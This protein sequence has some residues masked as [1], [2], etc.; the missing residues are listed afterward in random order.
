M[1]NWRETGPNT[2]KNSIKPLIDSSHRILTITV[3]N[4]CKPRQ[5]PWTSAPERQVKLSCEITMALESMLSISCI[6]LESKLLGPKVCRL[7]YTLLEPGEPR[8]NRRNHVVFREIERTTPCE[9]VFD[10]LPVEPPINPHTLQVPRPRFKLAVFDMDS[11]LVDQE[12]IDELARSIGLT[13]AV[14]A[15]TARAMN[16]EIDFEE[17]LKE[18]VALLKG[19]RAD[20]WDALQTN[21][22]ITI[23]KGAIELI[24]RLR[25]MGVITAVVSGGFLPMAD[26]LKMQLGLNYASANH[27]LTSPPS[28]EYP[29]E[30][31]NGLLDPEKQIV[32]AQQKEQLLRCLARAHGIG[33]EQTLAVGDGSN[34]LLMMG[35][36]A[37]GV[38]WKA[39]ASVQ[40]KAPARLNGD[41]L[42]ELLYLFG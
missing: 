1:V 9:L 32:H 18:R 16:G 33:L 19:V 40:E 3:Y 15:I 30:H 42:E 34:D 28:K 31:L 23:A 25:D 6:F 17:S 27:L 22:S 8:L 20:I 12:V 29:Y 10:L 7:L 26:W 38:A 35:T 2:Y 37:L 21:G 41:S 11:T 5:C 13:K 39:K 24:S 4:R 36:A 14:S